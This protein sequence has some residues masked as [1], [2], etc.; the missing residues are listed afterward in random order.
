MRHA[1]SIPRRETSTSAHPMRCTKR[2][3]KY[4]GA[5][6]MDS[7][8]RQTDARQEMTAWAKQHPTPDGPSHTR[9]TPTS[10]ARHFLMTYYA[11]R[12]APPKET[13]KALADFSS[14]AI[15]LRRTEAAKT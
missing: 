1:L 14:R 11:H 4:L 13:Q 15:R 10:L 2:E 7:V 8:A 5:M 9:P 6:Q 12:A 3:D